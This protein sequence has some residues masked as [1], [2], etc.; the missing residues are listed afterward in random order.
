MK[1]FI[2][3]FTALFVFSCETTIESSESQSKINPY[4]FED[5]KNNYDV[6]IV[7]SCEYIRL[8]GNLSAGISHKG[9]CRFCKKRK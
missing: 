6:F 8:K 2:L 1:T 5:K 4:D 7:D 3:F 9:N